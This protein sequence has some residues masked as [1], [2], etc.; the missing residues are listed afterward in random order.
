MVAVVTGGASGI[1]L[2]TVRVLRQ[3]GAQV[4]SL[5]LNAG[6]AD[7]DGV[8]ALTADVSDTVSVQEAV[9]AATEHLGRLDVLVNN[10]GIGAQGTVEDNPEEEWRRV[11]EVNVL[12]IVRASRACLPHLRR[13]SAAAIAILARLRRP[14]VCQTELSMRPARALCSPLPWPWPPTT[15][16]RA[17]G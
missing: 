13:S 16:L 2:A 14:P 10:A 11:L 6:P 1:G 3:Q 9:R 15:F 12:G 5:D 17:S 8:L 4:A 7:Q